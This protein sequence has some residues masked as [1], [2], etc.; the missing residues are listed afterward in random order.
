LIRR[1]YILRMIEEF[2]RALARINAL[3]KDRRWDEAADAIDLEFKRLTGQGAQAVGR[4]PETE[5]LALAIAGE[6]TQAVRDKTLIL[7]S[8]L[9]EA[10]DIAVGQGRSVEGRDAQLKALHLLLETL[11]R[12]EV[13]EYP[14]FAPKVEV[15]LAAL[16]PDPLPLRTL[17]MLMQHYERGGE[18]AQA[19][20]ILFAM[21]DTEPPNAAIIEFGTAFY[22]RLLNQSNVALE[23]GNLPRAEVEQGLK[24]LEARRTAGVWAP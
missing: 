18:F 2:I 19:E 13:F 22:R 24:E 14:E 3:K 1:D 11:A 16:Q 12:G 17:A 15:F 21:I 4:L 5:L 9:K 23:A 7:T 10:G 6:P 20:N 8:L